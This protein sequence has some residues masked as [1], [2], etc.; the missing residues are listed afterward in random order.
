M[1]RSSA[2]VLGAALLFLLMLGHAAYG[3]T[4]KETVIYP[5]SAFPGC[6]SPVAPLI[7]DASG[8]LYGTA[9]N[10]GTYQHGCVFE[11]SPNA[12]GT[13]NEATLYIFSGPDGQFPS[14]PLTF[15]RSGNLYGTAKSGGTYNSG[16]AFELSPSANGQWAETVLYNFGNG[17]DGAAPES[18]LVFDSLR[19]PY[20][21]TGAGGARRGGTVF[22]LT[23]GSNG[24]AET[25]LY[26]FPASVGGPDGDIPAGGV[27]LGP[28]GRIYGAT[29]FGGA[30]GAGAVYELTPSATGYTEQLIFSFL[31][32]NGLEPNSSLVMDSK[33]R[34][35][36]TTLAGGIGWGNVFRLTRGTNGTWTEQILHNFGGNNGAN[37]FYPVGP[38]CLDRL[39]DVFVATMSGGGP[40]P[41]YGTVHVLRPTTNGTW[42]DFILHVFEYP[43]GGTDGTSPY[44]GVTLVH[45][46]LFGTTSRG[47]IN[48]D[49]TVFSISAN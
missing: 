45:G 4:I 46:Q 27:V 32:N 37:G 22:R 36:G 10:G 24:W 28:Q 30:Q 5:F 49:G 20:G 19:N 40:Y 8:N 13:W 2:R 6:N 31:S 38:I 23:P 18:E 7:A 42:N 14:A 48:D 17:E 3:A 29:G 35:Y 21:T 15:D 41:D 47:G 9:S 34:L 12:D 39:G 25:I 26:D 33:G 1:I 16:V 43:V 44:A 11:L